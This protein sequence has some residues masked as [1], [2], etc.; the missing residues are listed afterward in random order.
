MLREF[1]GVAHY[2]AFT[3]H[4]W[5]LI[6]AIDIVLKTFPYFFSLANTILNVK[7]STY[8][9]V[10]LRYILMMLSDEYQVSQKSLMGAGVSYPLLAKIHG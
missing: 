9:H 5:Y 6:P 1:F 2:F 10:E 4:S 8:C 3:S 7:E